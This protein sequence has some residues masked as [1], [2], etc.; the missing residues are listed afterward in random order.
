MDYF[1]DMTGK[2]CFTVLILGLFGMFTSCAYQSARD[3]NACVVASKSP[4]QAK[5]CERAR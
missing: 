5:E 4:E 3:H 2:I 1:F